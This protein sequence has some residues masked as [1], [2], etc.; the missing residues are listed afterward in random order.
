MPLLLAA[1][2]V[3]TDILEPIPEHLLSLLYDEAWGRLG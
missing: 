3:T 2:D 1:G